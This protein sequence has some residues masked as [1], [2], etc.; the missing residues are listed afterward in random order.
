MTTTSWQ[1]QRPPG[2]PVAERSRAEA[3]GIGCKNMVQLVQLRWLAVGGQI[4][5]IAGVTLLLGLRLPLGPMVAV[6][7]GLVGLNIASL[8]LLSRRRTVANTELFAALMLDV[9]AL[10]VQLYFSGGATNPFIFLCNS[11][12]LSLGSNHP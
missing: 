9:A 5:T 6:L 2:P 10:G 1:D 4:V 3:H 8:L 12:G 7:M 11:P